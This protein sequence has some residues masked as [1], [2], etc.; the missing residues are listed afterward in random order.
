MPPID[1]FASNDAVA[2]RDLNRFIDRHMANQ[3]RI[4]YVGRGGPYEISKGD[5][6]STRL[7]DTL[8]ADVRIAVVFYTGNWPYSWIEKQDPRLFVVTHGQ[9]NHSQF[10]HKVS[11]AVHHGKRLRGMPESKAD[12]FKA[13]LA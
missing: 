9:V 7:I 8:L 13:A 6:S 3:L 2:T 1:T 10:L 5:C 12:C 4:V 11:V